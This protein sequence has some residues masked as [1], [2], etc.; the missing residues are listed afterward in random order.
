V[1]QYCQPSD[2]Q[3]AINPLALVSITNA[4]QVQACIDASN[5]ADNY[6]RGRYNL[7][8][9][10]PF[11]TG[12]IRHTA[13][14]AVYLLMSARGFNP[15]MG[16]DATIEANYHKAVGDPRYPGTG[17]FPGIQRQI[18]HPAVIET[19]PT[20]GS[21]TQMPQVSTSP[22]RGWGAIQGRFG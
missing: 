18:I 20:M 1:S 19:T 8:L 11:D 17:Y 15:S 9:L 13:F 7:P 21:P 22:Q 10:T 4:Q 12:I 16:A 5:E 2:L 14:I 6:M 3:N